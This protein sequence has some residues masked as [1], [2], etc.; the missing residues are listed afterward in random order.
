MDGIDV[1]ADSFSPRPRLCGASQQHT[2]LLRHGP[3]LSFFPGPQFPRGGGWLLPA[4]P[5]PV[6]TVAHFTA[7]MKKVEAHLNSPEFR[8]PGGRGLDG[9]ARDMHARCAEV[10]K[11]KGQRIPK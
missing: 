7:R 10:V 8:M 5:P 2:L 11:R 3:C 4:S 9:L 6:E 1:E